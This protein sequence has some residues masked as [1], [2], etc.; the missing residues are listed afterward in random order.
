MAETELSELL[1]DLTDDVKK[2]TVTA[3]KSNEL[4]FKTEYYWADI[5]KKFNYD[6][7]TGSIGFSSSPK[8]ISKEKLDAFSI[9]DLHN[10]K[11]AILPSFIKAS[12]IIAKIKNESIPQTDYWLS[13]FTNSIIQKTIERQSNRKLV[14]SAINFLHEIEDIDISWY[15]VIWLEGIIIPEKEI[16]IKNNLV[17]RQPT[18]ED[19]ERKSGMYG[20]FSSFEV[21]SY[22]S[23]ILLLTIKANSQ[24]VAQRKIQKII[25]ALQLYK[26]GSIIATKIKWK[27]DSV[28]WM[29]GGTSFSSRANV[30]AYRYIIEEKD[31]QSLSEFLSKIESLIPEDVI[32]PGTDE[33]DYLTIAIQRYVDSLLK[34]EIAES[35]L[36]F[37][38]MCLEALYLKQDERQ[39]LEHRL[40]Q[41]ISKTLYQFGH[42]PLEIFNKVKRSYEIR[43]S[44]V[45]GS[46]IPKNK[47]SDAQKLAEDILEYARSS[48]V[49]QL[50]LKHTMDKEKL[51]ALVDNSLLN[52]QANT[53][54]NGLLK[55]Y[56]KVT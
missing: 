18:K 43:S 20:A 47:Q 5:F 46:P 45:H 55:K 31:T 52:P 10:S 21:H 25:T 7:T 11:I 24:S 48:I 17:F 38:M 22:P 56:C 9:H 13:N 27:S 32:S 26:V 23:C 44:F 33:V 8:Q 30:S 28:M 4:K 41:R 29:G 15:P 51:L 53:K 34:P 37:A 39:E 12:K 42:E 50:Q 54:L 19:I 14:L 2:I 40:A 3:L 6:K 49:I 1:L 16:K 36:T 35:R